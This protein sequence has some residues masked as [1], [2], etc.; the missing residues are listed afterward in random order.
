[1]RLVILLVI[2]LL[3]ILAFTNPN[4]AEF[5]AH[6]QQKHGIAG[7]LS[8][9]VASIFS[10]GTSTGVHRDNYFLFSRYYV[11][12]DGVLPRSDLAWGVGGKFFDIAENP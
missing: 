4:E 7:T 11:G 8:L 10:A 2:A 12:G 6:M 3:V 5:R 9:K 1:M